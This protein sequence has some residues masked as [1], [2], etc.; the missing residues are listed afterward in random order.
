MSS[1]LNSSY[2][3]KKSM[4]SCLVDSDN[5]AAFAAAHAQD[6][7]RYKRR[8]VENQLAEKKS[9]GVRIN[10]DKR[11]WPGKKTDTIRKINMWYWASLYTVA[12]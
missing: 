11:G 5:S 3:T 1:E 7:S 9:T 8:Y 10:P 4:Y 6:L 2:M 12:K